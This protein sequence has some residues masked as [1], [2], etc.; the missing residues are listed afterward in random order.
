M[1]ALLSSV[2][3]G[4]ESLAIG[5][6][7]DPVP[8]VGEVR[9]AVRACAIN[10]PD[11]LIIEDRYQFK[12]ERPFSPGVEVSG[13]VEALGPD[14][15]GLTV[16]QRVIASVGWGGLAE[17]VNAEVGKC[18]SMPDDVPFDVGASLLVT[19]G[20]SYHALVDKAAIAPGE[21]LF[22]LGASGGVGLAA[23]EIGRALGARVVAGVSTPEKAEIARAAG[24]SDV[25]I[26]PTTPDDP[27]ALAA[28]FKSALP[29]GADVIYDAVGGGYAEP[30][31]RSIAWEGRY[32]V[33]GFAAGIP[34][35]PFNLALLKG[36]SIIG[37][38]WGAWLERNAGQH[39]HNN[40]ALLQMYRDGLI[41]PLISERFPL[42]RGGEAIRRLADRKAVGKLIV[43][44]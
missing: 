11:V 15:D 4:P 8:G 24:A 35:P 16:G 29:S 19:Y 32:L 17:K 37:I 14:V 25:V 44:P 40:Q 23:V 5:E 10:Y 43:I 39:Q 6:R 12:P 18:V 28:L 21:T 30:A 27:R 2:P 41:K 3:G 22:V 7:P 34:A 31:L 42:E 38:F 33:I 9:L 13:I 36:C 1:K 26:Y 20:T